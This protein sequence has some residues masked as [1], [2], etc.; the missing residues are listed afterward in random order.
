MQGRYFVKLSGLVVIIGIDSKMR[1]LRKLFDAGQ[2]CV[3]GYQATLD[4]SSEPL[5]II[6]S[7]DCSDKTE[8]L[9]SSILVHHD[10]PVSRLMLS[11][12]PSR[13]L[14]SKNV[15]ILSSLDG[16]C[17]EDTWEDG[18]AE[19]QGLKALL[20]NTTRN[21]LW[22]IEGASIQSSKPEPAMI[23]GQERTA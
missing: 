22:I 16:V 10:G 15:I 11:D 1:G 3:W 13:G 12:L 9:I 20:V 18:D 8:S 23:H 14:D 2:L 17:F 4:F 5:T 6:T 7:E 19:F 21:I